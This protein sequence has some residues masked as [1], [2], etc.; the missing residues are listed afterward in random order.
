MVV[1]VEVTM[2]KFDGL[3]VGAV[4][5]WDSSQPSFDCNDDGDT[6]VDLWSV[7]M[8]IVGPWGL[9]EGDSVVDQA[10]SSMIFPIL[11]PSRMEDGSREWLESSN[12]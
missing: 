9:I 2:V 7:S 10:W 5:G 12:R 1:D 6:I 11:C 4:D 8:A 3:S